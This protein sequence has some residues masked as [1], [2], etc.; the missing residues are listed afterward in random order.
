MDLLVVEEHRHGDFGWGRPTQ[1][2]L[3]RVFEVDFRVEVLGR[4]RGDR[5]TG[6]RLGRGPEVVVPR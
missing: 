1:G 3:N 5:A 6:S 4:T 2:D